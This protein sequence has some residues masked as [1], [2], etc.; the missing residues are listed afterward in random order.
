MGV[1]MRN[2]Q[3]LS[4]QSLGNT[5]RKR[6]RLTIGLLGAEIEESYQADV[7]QGVLQAAQ[8]HD[9]NVFYVVG[10][11]LRSPNGFEA[12]GNVLYDLVSQTA[13]DGL[14]I[15]SGAIGN[16]LSAGEI[17]DFCARYRPLPAVSVALQLE[18]FPSL[19][20]DNERGVRE[21]ILHLIEAHGY[22]RIAFIRGP[23]GH[24]EAEERYRGY[25]EALAQHGLPLDLN[26][27]A[28]G[29]FDSECGTQAIQ[30][31][32][33][34]RGQTFEAIVAADDGMAIS[35]M[36]ALRA[37]GL[38]VPYDVAVA[39][40]DDVADARFV[41][42]PLTTVR[43]PLYELGRQAVE[44]LMALLQGRS[45]PEMTVLHTDVVVR[46]SCGCFSS[47]TVQAAVGTSS[48][49]DSRVSLAGLREPMLASVNLA[50]SACVA[51]HGHE[52]EFSHSAQVV[53]AFII[54]LNGGLPN[55]F[56]QALDQALQQLIALGG[57]VEACHGMIAAL[58]GQVLPALAGSDERSR[59]EDLCHQ[60]QVLISESAHRAEGARRRQ[61]EEQA[62]SLREVQT[63]LTSASELDQF[64]EIAAEQVSQLGIPSAYLS[65][66]EGPSNPAQQ[67]R[68]FMAYDERGRVQLDG[69]GQRFPARQLIPEAL[70][71][72]GRR[73]TMVVLPLYFRT[74]QL[75]FA[76]LEMGPQEG[77][78]YQVLQGQLSSA[79]QET[80][81][82]RE[83]ERALRTEERLM[84][85]IRELSTPVVPLLAGA[86]LLPLVGHIDSERARQAMEALLEGVRA[87]RAQV[88]ILDITGVPV[89]DTGVANHLLQAAQAVRLLGAR[90]VLVGIR[91]EVAQ[92]IVGLGV[93]LAGMST[94]ANLQKGIEYALQVMEARI[95][96]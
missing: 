59:A 12:Q 87:Y 29:N 81:L 51:G 5:N 90:V 91:A 41:T 49:P 89:V 95:G 39:G 80:L 8:E 18:G 6:N 60:A 75:G 82:L 34:E 77:V 73:Y 4:A 55:L 37:H 16:Y 31:L 28:P 76:V 47:L 30:L 2:P 65:L 36:E 23:E 68:L 50:M 85:T 61:S 53:D 74:S 78:L 67:V 72:T 15:L 54:E 20:V 40:F 27:V 92:T 84:E 13:V 25:Q 32:L 56:L 93:D 62:Q 88:A 63:T 35:A 14:V 66:Y 9:L 24:A 19:V 58:R 17:H 70:L 22:R 10:G 69:D 38:R 11:A 26:L 86:I 96:G 43:Q 48:F 42:P 83:R 94:A 46:Q 45:A 3:L 52:I 64:V 44:M 1:G 71:P 79:L 21:A 33:D 57:D 7:S